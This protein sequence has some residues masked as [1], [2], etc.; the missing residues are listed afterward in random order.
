M[1]IAVIGAGN[2]GQAIAGYLSM[3]SYEVSLYDRDKQK[4]E[5]LQKKG[6]IQLEGKIQGFGKITHITN[7]L[8]DAIK[9]AKVIM[10][11]TVANAHIDIAHAMASS[12]ED[13]QVILLNPGRTC[14]AIVFKQALKES[15][16]KVRYYLG[17]AQ[18]LVYACRV[19]ENGRVNIIGIKDKVLL[20]GLPS[21]DTNYI[22]EQVRT[23]Y[24]CFKACENVLHTSFENIGAMF[25]PCVCLFNAATI[26][27]QRQFYFYR[28]MTKQVA[29]F[30]EKFDAERLSVGRAYGIKL[31]S[32][33]EWIKVAYKDTKGDTLCERMQNNPGYY[34]IKGP[35]TIFTRQLTE[36]IPTGVLPIRDLGKVAGVTTPLLDSM[37]IIIEA[38]LDMDLHTNGR[39]LKNL[40]LEHKTKEEILEFIKNEE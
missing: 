26:E 15:K 13:G 14:G 12:I 31:L 11:T 16:C 4:I 35:G 25:H 36:D 40:G 20:S 2:G 30:I 28:D 8:P 38:L 21:C 22:L 9:K 33:N 27:R 3:S 17:E 32:V 37:I 34:D 23:F 24:P 7:V 10:V 6:G 39:S 5:Q 18:T 29:K 19:V 1:K